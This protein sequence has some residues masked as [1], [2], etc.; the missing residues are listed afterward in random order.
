MIRAAQLPTDH[1]IVKMVDARLRNVLRLLDLRLKHATWLAGDEFTAADT[2]SV[3]S[4]TKVKM[5]M[6][7]DLSGYPQMLRY[8]GRDA[9]AKGDPGFTPI[10]SGP[11]R[12]LFWLRRYRLKLRNVGNC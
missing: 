7:F 2:M 12:E 10:L 8:L 5:F 9:M 3:S 4:L 6:P 11:A 1:P